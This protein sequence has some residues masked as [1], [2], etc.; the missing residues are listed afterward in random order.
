MWQK[1]VAD[2]GLKKLSP[3]RQNIDVSVCALAAGRITELLAN[4]EQY[5]SGRDLCIPGVRR[6]VLVEDGTTA[7]ICRLRG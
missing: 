2:A 5:R 6:T 1:K 7:K 4:E 3:S